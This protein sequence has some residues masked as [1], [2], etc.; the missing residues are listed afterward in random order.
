M[1]DIEDL[2]RRVDDVL[3][4]RGKGNE[5]IGDLVATEATPEQWYSPFNVSHQQRAIE[6]T[7]RLR[8]IAEEKGGEEGL[9][10]AVTEIERARDTA[11]M[12]RLVQHATKLFLMHHPEARAKLRLKPLEQRQPDLVRPS[13]PRRTNPDSNTPPREQES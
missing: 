3:S 6:L 1:A 7:S 9:A 2:Q 5:F 10:D 8:Q 13:T 11:E 4:G 12:P